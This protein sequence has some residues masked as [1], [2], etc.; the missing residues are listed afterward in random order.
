MLVAYDPAKVSTTELLRHFWE[1]H[2]PTQGMRQGNDVGSQYRSAIYWTTE[3]QSVLASESAAAYEPV[4]IDRGYG[5]VTTEI[6]PAEGRPFYYA[7]EYHQQYLYKVPNGYRCHSQ[8]GV[9]LP[10]PS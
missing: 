1:E 6:A 9:P 2:D 4:L 7:E 8:T 10:W 5:T 3:E